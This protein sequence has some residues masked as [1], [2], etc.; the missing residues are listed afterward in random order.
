MLA[1]AWLG[2]KIIVSLMMVYFG[3]LFL[4]LILSKVTWQDV[5]LWTFVLLIVYSFIMVALD[6]NRGGLG[7]IGRTFIGIFG[8]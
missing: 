6:P 7:D 5:A 4:I 8:M 3:F 2:I 1:L